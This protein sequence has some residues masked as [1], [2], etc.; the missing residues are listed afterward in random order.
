MYTAVQSAVDAARKEG[1]DYVI[2]LAHL[3]I[4]KDCEPW[5][6]S[7]VINNTT[8]ID[9]MLDGHSHSVIEKELVKNKDGKDV[10]LSST[11]TKLENIGCLTIS[12]DGK[13]DV[14]LLNDDGIGEYIAD[15][16]EEFDGLVNEV[17]A[18]TD[19]DLAVYD[20]KNPEERLILSLIHI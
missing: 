10:I 19:V 15:I 9:V 8:G 18:H 1:A 13:L 14:E 2:A 4:E 11:G 17:V 3:G 6:S 5:T 12:A 7:D 16:Q 20:P